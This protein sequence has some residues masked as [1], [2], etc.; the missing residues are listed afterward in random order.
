MATTRTMQDMNLVSGLRE[1]VFDLTIETGD[2][3]AGPIKTRLDWI[4]SLVVSCKSPDGSANAVDD[5]IICGKNTKTESGAENDYGWVFV[6]GI[7]DP[8]ATVVLN[9]RALGW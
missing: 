8:T 6:T 3:V 1:D 7:G 2:N 5:T 4:E 9:C